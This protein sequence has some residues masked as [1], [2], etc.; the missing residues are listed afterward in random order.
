MTR[1]VLGPYPRGLDFDRMQRHAMDV[2]SLAL[3]D[4]EQSHREP[5]IKKGAYLDEGRV[6]APPQVSPLRSDPRSSGSACLWV[7]II[8]QLALAART[9]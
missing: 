3:K 9:F 8:R 7:P 2:H 6:V 4:L 5:E 1:F